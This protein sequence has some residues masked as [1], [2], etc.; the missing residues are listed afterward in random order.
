MDK[1]Y[2]ITFPNLTNRH[3]LCAPHCQRG[4]VFAFRYNDFGHERTGIIMMESENWFYFA[5]NLYEEQGRIW[6]GDEMPD[7]IELY[8]ALWTERVWAYEEYLTYNSTNGEVNPIVNFMQTEY[9]KKEHNDDF[10]AWHLCFN[11]ISAIPWYILCQNKEVMTEI[12][13]ETMRGIKDVG[14]QYNKHK[15]ELY[16]F[17]LGIL[18]I[19]KHT[20]IDDQ[21][22]RLIEQLNSNWKH[23]SW[24]Y[25]MAIGRV[26]GC[27]FSN[28]TSMVNSISGTGFDR[29]KYSHLYLPLVENNIDNIC[30]NSAIV[31]KEKLTTAV[32]KLRTK[33]EQVVQQHDLDNLYA[34][35]F[36]EYFTNMLKENKVAASIEEMKQELARKDAQLQQWKDVVTEMSSQ[37]EELTN[38]MK[39]SVEQSLSITDVT[40]A[41]LEMNISLAFTVFSSLDAKLYNNKV[42]MDHRKD[43]LNELNDRE[44]KERNRNGDTT[45]IVQ[46]NYNDIHNNT[47]P[48]IKS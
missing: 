2:P 39:T 44:R 36:P 32:A 10:S 7:N 27:K 38:S 33:S 13:E 8:E 14:I 25:A 18:M 9:P 45:I 17:V 3:H 6:Y 12:W 42:W 1:Q 5:Y 21:R 26:L 41:I 48:T 19:Y 35:L 28:I 40:R 30:H 22:K 37:L 43:L 23:F 20:N 4:D 47:N 29:D 46:G 16:C 31:N 24:M 11:I 15:T 34:I